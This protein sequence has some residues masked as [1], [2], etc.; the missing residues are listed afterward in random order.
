[1]IGNAFNAADRREAWKK[2]G[3]GKKVK[4]E[5]RHEMNSSI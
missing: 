1:M 2:L 4:Q 3:G 5:V